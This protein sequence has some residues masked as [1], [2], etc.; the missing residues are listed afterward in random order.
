M[1]GAWGTCI[2]YYVKLNMAKLCKLRP[3]GIF[4]GKN[5]WQTTLANVWQFPTG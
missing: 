3:F 4:M 1:V 5:Q 2:L